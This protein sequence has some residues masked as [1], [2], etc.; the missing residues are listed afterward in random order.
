MS[1]DEKSFTLVTHVVRPGDGQGRVNY[2]VVREALRQGWNATLIASEI[3]P[4]LR[5][6]DRVEWVP[7]QSRRFPSYLLREL[8]FAGRSTRAIR[9]HR[10]GILLSNGCI[11]RAPADL[12]AC[13]FVHSSW[14]ASPVH[15]GRI[16]KGPSAAYHRLYSAVNARLE[17]KAYAAA[18][19]VVSVSEQVRRELIAVG[20]DPDKIVTIPNG[21][22]TGEFTPELPPDR[23]RFGLPENVPLALFAGDLRSPRKNLDS[24]LKAMVG[25]PELHLAVAGWLETSPYPAMAESLGLSSR[26]HFLGNIREMARL[27]RS[28]DVF[29]FPSRYEACSLVML[30]AMATGLPV[31]TAKTTGGAELVPPDGGFL[32]DGP[33]DLAGLE[34]ILR[35]VVSD[36]DGLKTMSERSRE[37]A[38]RLHW[39]EM[40]RK[41]IALMETLR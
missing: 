18:R 16:A 1:S 5:A 2:E 30:E 27:M 22:D 38:L 12:N 4:D 29:A 26:V 35:R 9:E 10:R 3:A 23:S 13:H 24:V 15:P 17:K 36:R 20:I 25:V 31:V 14:L 37:A 11:T 19:K 39:N 8:V 7:V 40:G 33:D 32:M 6:H 34:S 28:C 21:V 41:Y